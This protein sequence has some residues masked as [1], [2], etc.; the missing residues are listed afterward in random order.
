MPAVSNLRRIFPCGTERRNLR[1]PVLCL[2][3]VR[4]RRQW[5]LELAV[6][7]AIGETMQARRPGGL[8]GSE[9]KGVRFVTTPEK[10]RLPELRTAGFLT[11]RVR[12]LHSKERILDTFMPLSS[13]TKTGRL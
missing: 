2:R 5:L 3:K 11:S 4:L 1:R 9:Y 10:E 8:P 7:G 13:G 6:L 12:S